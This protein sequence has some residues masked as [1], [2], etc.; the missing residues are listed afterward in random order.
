MSLDDFLSE[1][2]KLGDNYDM[3]LRLKKQFEEEG[4]PDNLATYKASWVLTPQK[5]EKLKFYVKNEEG[6]RIGVEFFFDSEEELK[7]LSKYFIFNP[8]TKQVKDSN[9]L[10]ELLKL[11]EETT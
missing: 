4:L 8:N 10:I 5:L 1:K 7:L 2:E 9:L 6:L 11:L 3:F